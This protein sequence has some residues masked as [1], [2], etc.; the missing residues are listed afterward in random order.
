VCNICC[1]F[2]ELVAAQSQPA[3]ALPKFSFAEKCLLLANI[4][5]DEQFKET[6]KFSAWSAKQSSPATESVSTLVDLAFGKG[7]AKR[8]HVTQS[9]LLIGW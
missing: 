9:C 6:A 8:G 7:V 1:I 3:V 5:G 4:L 2:V